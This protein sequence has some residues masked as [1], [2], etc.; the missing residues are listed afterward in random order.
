PEQ[1]VD[2]F[3]N[4]WYYTVGEILVRANSD[5][6]RAEAVRPP[7]GGFFSTLD[8]SRHP[9]LAAIGARWPDLAARDVYRQG[10]SAFVDGL[11]AQATAKPPQ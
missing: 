4:I 6:R 10:L 5:G 2:V 8:A 9:Q 11:L 3:R 7:E 1:A